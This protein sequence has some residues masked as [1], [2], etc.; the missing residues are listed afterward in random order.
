MIQRLK[1]IARRIVY[2]RNQPQYTRNRELVED[3]QTT[4]EDVDFLNTLRIEKDAESLI[5]RQVTKLE[6]NSSYLVIEGMAWFE[7]YPEQDTERII[8]SL[9]LTRDCLKTKNSGII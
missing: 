4:K 7:K 5:K 8:K 1:R 6:F 9:I 3:A 2:G